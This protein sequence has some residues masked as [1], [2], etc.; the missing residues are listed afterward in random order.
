M[1]TSRR[2][3]SPHSAPAAPDRY[4]FSILMARRRADIID[5]LC[6]ARGQPCVPVWLYSVARSRSRRDAESKL[7]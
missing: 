6:V 1:T 2:F 5:S 4:P 3:R 7:R